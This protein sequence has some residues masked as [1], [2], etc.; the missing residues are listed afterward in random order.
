MKNQKEWVRKH[1]CPLSS[2]Y[3]GFYLQGLRETMKILSG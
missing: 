3:P 1:L 2:Q